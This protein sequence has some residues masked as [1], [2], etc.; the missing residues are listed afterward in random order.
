VLGEVPRVAE[1]TVPLSDPGPKR[2]VPTTTETPDVLSAT[3]VIT[4]RNRVDELLKA[5]RSALEQDARPSVLVIDDGSTDSTA[6]RV[7]AEFPTVRVE[8]VE[9]PLGY[10]VQRNRAAEL[11]DDADVI[12]SIDDDAVFSTPR[13]VGQTLA[14]LEGQPRVGA[15]AIPFVNVNREDVVRQRAPGDGGVFVTGEFI[16]TAHAVRRDAFR[17]LGGYRPVLFHQGEERDFCLRLLDAGL[18]VRL[19]RAD[20]VHHFESPRRDTRRM[21]LYGRRNDVLFAWHNVPWPAFP[22][23]LAAT[24]VGGLRFGSRVGRPVRMAQGLAMG[25]AAVAG[26]W[27]HRRPVSRAAYRLGRRLRHGSLPL[28][29]VEP[30]LPAI[31]PCDCG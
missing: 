1:A 3:V 27:S 9:R 15:V 8:R 20:P 6:D 14:E 30:L 21:D 31:A 23:H 22:V 24:T 11:A 29:V 13:T 19:G 4:T 5:I 7:R 28:A 2:S 17:R 10:I 18:V 25:Y 16:G 26:E 12:V